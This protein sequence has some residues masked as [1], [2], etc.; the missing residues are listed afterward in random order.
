MKAKMKWEESQAVR[1]AGMLARLIVND[2][3]VFIKHLIKHASC[4]C[5]SECTSS[6]LVQCL[7]H[8]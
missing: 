7:A 8:L 5:A 4:C 6:L 3:A 1:P 2:K